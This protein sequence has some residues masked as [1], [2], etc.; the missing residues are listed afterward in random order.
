[1]STLGQDLRYS[2]RA[3]LRSPVFTLAAILTLAIGVAANTANFSVV[4]AF[5]LRPLPFDEPDELV[6][7]FRFD[8]QKG[9]DQL[10]LAL[11]TFLELES[12]SQSFEGMAAYI[13][14]ARNLAGGDAQPERLTVGWVSSNLFSLLG[15]EA[16]QGR[17]F[18]PEDGR[19]GAPPVAL[20][21]HGVWQRRFGGD[22]ATV[23]RTVEIDGERVTVVGVM[24]PR[25]NF[26]YGGVKMWMPL[27]EEAA[28]YDRS[29]RS[30]L[31]VGRLA[32]GASV[33]RALAETE[34]LFRRLQREHYPDEVE[35]GLRIVPL[36]EALIFFYDM[37]RILLILI[38]V[39]SG[40]VL[41]IICTNISNLFLVRCA[42]REREFA[43]RAALGAGRLHVIRQLLTEGLVLALA[44]GAL[45]ALLAH[46]N[47]QLFARNFPED[48][49]RVGQIEVDRAA[50]LFTLGLSVLT[51]CV[52]ALPPA[53]QTLKT[54]LSLALKEGDAVAGMGVKG[55]RTQ[56]VLVVA[57]VSLAILL[58]VGTVLAVQSFRHLQNVDP[59]FRAERV[60][61]VEMHLPAKQ[62]EETARV[63][64][65]YRRLIERVEAVPGV[66]SAA[67]VHPLPLNFES[68]GRSFTVEGRDAPAGERLYAGEHLVS[69]RYFETMGIQLL[70]GRAFDERDGPEAVPAVI[71]SKGLADRFWPGGAL[72]GQIRYVQPEGGERVA[73][74][75]GVAADTKQMLLF[76]EGK[77][78]LYFPQRQEPT[79]R[80]FLL[81]QTAGDPLAAVAAVREAVWSLEPNLPL[82]TVRSL[83]QVVATSLQP[84]R[85]STLVLG[86][87]TGVS[88]LLAGIGIYGVI[89][90]AIGRRTREIGLRMALGAQPRDVLTLVIRKALVLTAIGVV[91][92]GAAALALSHGLKSVLFGVQAT[93]P[94]IYLAAL[95]TL[96]GVALVA[97]VVPALRAVRIDPA[98]ALRFE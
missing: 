84:W 35:T 85:W 91:L 62:Y 46:W 9:F 58:L 76:E 26:P 61:T 68:H 72:G 20:L 79:R 54:D 75:V 28:R 70:R 52:F 95:A 47:L 64:A 92:G 15:V 18:V 98:V 59:G 97:S 57:Q 4:N 32:A 66:R 86:L 41:L 80:E 38:T 37:V 89:A 81:V 31:V 44:G 63:T 23:G 83:D 45:G 7:L 14:G 27:E 12:G 19:P 34:V 40:F 48:L 11:P 42:G 96:A 71:V 21:G 74:V 43:I 6:H 60:L 8:R 94:S 5:L 1:M 65:F 39:A 93:D 49:F 3:L 55:R 53:L 69:S 30:F 13:Y 36:R 90:Y 22:P 10:R 73:T 78:L 17:T 2:L 87:F 25:F 77:G 88:L 24:P 56:S 51:A 16:E 67:L 50:L 33:E 29:Y 82:G